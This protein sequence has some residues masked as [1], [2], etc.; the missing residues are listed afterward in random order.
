[1]NNKQI[2][3]RKYANAFLNLYIDNISEEYFGSIKKLEKFFD[4]H[5]KAVFF[6]SVP[7]IENKQKEK[8]LNELFEKFSVKDLLKPLMRLLFAHKRIFLIDEVLKHIRL[9]Y[10]ERKNIMM[11]TITS[12]HQ[13]DGQDLEI[14]KRFLAYKTGKKIV[15]EYSV[16]KNI[17]AGIRLQSSTLLWEYS[18][19]KQC[20]T[21]RKQFNL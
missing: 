9:L 11:F 6:L 16:D 7:N 8:L 15:S 14:I 1:M 5:K 13:L 20:E 4:S 3:A 17:V 21:L 19:S 12:S 18:I 10:K 2:V